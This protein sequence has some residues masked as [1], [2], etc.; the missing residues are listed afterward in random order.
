MLKNNV[1]TAARTLDVF[2]AFVE[3][4]TP[5]SLTELADRI[6]IP[7]SSCSSLIHTLLDRG[8]LYRVGRRSEVYPTKRLLRSAQIIDR[9]DPIARRLAPVLEDLRTRTCETVILGR[10]H[11][12]L[13]VYLDVLEGPRTVRYSAGVG[14]FKPLHSSSIGKAM[15]GCLAA[16]DLAATLAR[17][18]LTAVTARTITDP[19]ALAADIARGRARGWYITDRENVPDATGLAAAVRLGDIPFGIA[20]AAPAE[21]M[22]ANFDRVRDALLAAAE[23]VEA[24]A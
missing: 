21:R 23:T 17:L 12:D 7:I 20:V 2:E 1:R 6:A 16:D 15:L 13:V 5:L 18:T 4:K 14:E 8:Y 22:E 9:H 24:T 10:R 19:D 3:G 11:E